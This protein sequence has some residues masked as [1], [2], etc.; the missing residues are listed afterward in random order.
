MRKIAVIISIIGTM[1]GLASCGR[2]LS[3]SAGELT[4]VRMASWKEPT[5]YGMTLVPQGAYNMGFAEADSIWGFEK[6]A[7]G[8]SVDAFWMDETEITNAKYRQFVYYVRD[9][10]IRERLA[11]PAYAGNELFKITEDKYGDPI[12]P[13][14]DWSRPIP[15]KGADEDEMRAI[16]SVYY[17]NPVTGE[18]KLDPKQMVF[19]YEWYDHTTASLRRNQLDPEMR[20]RNTDIILDPSE[21]IMI[22][23]DTA[24]IDDRGNVINLTITRPRRNEYDFLNTRM[25]RVCPDETCWIN[26]FNNAYNEPYTRMYFNHPGYDDY[27][28]VGVSWMQ[29]EAFCA[30][31]S[32][33]YKSSINLPKG[34][35]IEDYRLP[36]EAEWE[37]AARGGKNERRFPW[38][39]EQLTSKKGCFLGNFKPG[40]GNYTEDGHLITSR[41][42]SFAPNDFGLYDMAGNVAEWTSTSYSESGPTQMNDMNPELSYNAAQEDPYALKK[43]VVRGG[44][45]K[46]VAQFVRSDMRSYEYQNESRSYIGFRCV[47]TQVGFSSSRKGKK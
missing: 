17:T 28:V 44:S 40:E 27:P 12:E 38:D 3:G 23:K 39:S 20:N 29:A 9:S 46:D 34:M 16:E 18:K 43:K 37:Y 8:V 15:W 31:R 35:V 36:T 41:V 42:G 7:K 4:G 33:M 1:A 24:Y 10:I 32:Q 26:D 11:D 19:K 30:W 47:R 22:S 45:W 14:L 2:S 6:T 25:V 5:P 21:V 13:Y